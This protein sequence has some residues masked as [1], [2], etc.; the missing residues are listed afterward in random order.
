EFYKF[1]YPV[2]NYSSTLS[3]PDSLTQFAPYLVKEGKMQPIYII[4]VDNRPVY[5][6]MSSEVQRYSFAAEP[7]YHQV[8]IR[9]SNYEATVDSLYFEKGVKNIFSFL[10][11]TANHRIKL[12]KKPLSL[13]DHENKLISGHLIAIENNVRFT[14]PT[15]LKQDSKIFWINEQGNSQR[16]YL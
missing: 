10:M 2:L 12:V 1:L 11:D 9:T 4:Y 5:F 16:N 3:V 13:T 15:Y 8:R 7:G 6:S 14:A